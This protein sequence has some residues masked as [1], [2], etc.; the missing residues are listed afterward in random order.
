MRLTLAHGFGLTTMLAVA[1]AAILLTWFF[2]NRAFDA[3]GTKR[4]PALPILR[5]AAIL[6]VVLLLFQPAVNYQRTLSE[7]PAM[8]LLLDRSASMGIS[9]DASG[10]ARFDEARQK[11]AR[12]IEKLRDD[13][14]LLPIAFA[15]RATPLEDVHGFSTLTA[16]GTATSIVRALEAASKQ[17]P[18]SDE[19]IVLLLSDGVNN[20]AGNPLDA[21][22]KLKSPVYCI[23][24]GAGL[25][26][27][28]D[29]RDVRVTAIE[30]PDRMIVNNLA[31]ITGS[32]DAIGL[33]GRVVEV[34]CDEDDRQVARAELTLDDQEGSQPVRFEFTPSVKGRHAY[35]VRV[36]PTGDEKILQNNRRSAVA[37]VVEPGMRVL[38]VEGTLRPEYGALV[39]RFLA[40]DPDLEFCALVQTRPNVFARRTN[41]ADLRQ[42]AL[43]TDQKAFDQYDVFLIGDLDS[44]YLRPEQQEMIVRRVRAG[45]GMMMLGGYHSLGPGGYDG[46]P[47]GNI[48]PVALGGRQIGQVTDSFLPTLTPEGVRHPIFANIADYFPT[49]QGRAKIE[50]LPPLDGCTRI[51]RAKPGATTL[52]V[53]PKADSM[54]VL[55]V[56]PV[57]RG[58]TAVFT[59]DTTRAWQQAPRTLGQDSPFTR[60][61][62]QTV[63]WLAGRGINETTAGVTAS[64][65]KASYELGEPINIAAVV[66]DKD[67]RGVDNAK[68][69]AT[70]RIRDG[71]P[72]TVSLT[73]AVGRSGHFAGSVEPPSAGTYDVSVEARLGETFWKSDSIPVEVGRPNIEFEQLDLDELLLQRIA[74][75]TGGRYVP[76]ATA[77]HLIDQLDR[78][79]QRKTENVEMR[80]Y[81][82]VSYWTLIVI[83]L[84]VEWILRKKY[85]LR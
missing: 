28:R 8:V 54:P 38:Y 11:L 39:D 80:F 25:R 34:F 6:L 77:D 69:A 48:L 27:N 81:W 9:D 83:V 1:A 62:G 13:F 68:V 30:C 57:E 53:C 36:S 7:R 55:A 52:A 17:L 78:Q 46:T 5:I 12:W 74:E 43:P 45:A 79:Q 37:T 65:D 14:R 22:A 59:G 33:G 72:E 4:R 84:T 64:T 2:Y 10:V 66:R 50:G 75:A 20:A 26:A 82:P 49:G 18:P 24:V 56:Q 51:E 15:Q 31:R 61:W 21:A 47:L 63:R 60:F 42:D 58:R 23:G 73:P 67:G 16:D 35:T 29:Y 85:L 32:I 3:L 40:K 70:V 44:S 19:P 76:L 71:Q 41:I